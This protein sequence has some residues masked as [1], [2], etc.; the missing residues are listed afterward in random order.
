MKTEVLPE[1]TLRK[2]DVPMTREEMSKIRPT[3]ENGQLSDEGAKKAA[4]EKLTESQKCPYK[5]V[6]IKV[7]TW[8]GRP[9]L[10]GG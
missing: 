7:P 9:V 4:A 2:H 10:H 5:R 8:N 1:S 6:T 3:K